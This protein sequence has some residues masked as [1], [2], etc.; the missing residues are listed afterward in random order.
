[1]SPMDAVLKKAIDDGWEVTFRCAADAEFYLVSFKLRKGDR[2]LGRAIKLENQMNFVT[3][4]DIM[5]NSI[6]KTL[7]REKSLA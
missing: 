3:S 1:M 7:E 6:E 5:A 4:L 2:N